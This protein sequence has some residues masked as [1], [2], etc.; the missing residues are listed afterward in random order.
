M[1]DRIKE[2]FVYDPV[3]GVFCHRESRGRVKAGSVAGTPKDNYISIGMDKKTYYAHR[4]AYMYM[5]GEIPDGY[6]I[7]HIDGDGTNN[8]IGNL[9]LVDRLDN[10]NNLSN[11]KGY[12]FDSKTEKYM[13][14]IQH[15]GQRIN[16]GRFSTEKEARDAYLIARDGYSKHGSSIV[17]VFHVPMS[18]DVGV[19]K[20]K[21]LWL[22]TNNLHTLHHH[23]YNGAKRKFKKIVDSELVF[24]NIEYTD[25][26]T[27]E[28]LIFLPDKLNRDVANVGSVQDKFASDAYVELGFAPDDNYKYLQKV[29]Y[30]Y[31]GYDPN[32][33]GFAQVTVRLNNNRR[34]V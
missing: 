3:G 5:Y 8:S 31:G 18:I 14:L 19:R 10:C 30:A 4:L 1:L 11:A 2:L 24:R 20:K 12:Y 34:E 22:N 26:Y 23:Q 33:E 28:Y 7:D 16:L 25:N 15:K 6:E 17:S 9:R 21:T 29:E 32:K 13:A 27:L